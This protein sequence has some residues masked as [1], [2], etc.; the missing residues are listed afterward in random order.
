MA[1]NRDKF[2]NIVGGITTPE[3]KPETSPPALPAHPAVSDAP[4]SAPVERPAVKGQ[5]IE[6]N[7]PVVSS[8]ESVASD[9]RRFAKRGRP[10]GRKTASATDKIQKVKVSLF[11]DES[12]T[13]DLYEW[14]HQDKLHPG[15]MFDQALRFFHKHEKKRRN[16]EK[17]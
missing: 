3:I 7:G 8:D 10:K 16:A 12:I 1:M 6:S 13:N 17:G 9:T 5:G 14:A 15:E 11:I 4:V 2:R